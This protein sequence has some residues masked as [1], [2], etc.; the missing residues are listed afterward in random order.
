MIL[1]L[2][3]LATPTCVAPFTYQPRIEK[4]TATNP[5]PQPTAVNGHPVTCD[6]WGKGVVCYYDPKGVK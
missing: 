3:L 4:C 5:K 6:P 2:A 1:A